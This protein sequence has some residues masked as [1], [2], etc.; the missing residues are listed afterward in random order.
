MG[1]NLLVDFVNMLFLV[2]KRIPIGIYSS[3]SH[4]Q[5]I[6]DMK[7]R[8]AMACSKSTFNWWYGYNR[9]STYKYATV[10]VRL[11]VLVFTYWQLL[12]S[13]Q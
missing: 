4:G 7:S 9:T 12:T 1:G 6:I 11:V 10:I 13:S 2:L 8:K 5:I 3:H